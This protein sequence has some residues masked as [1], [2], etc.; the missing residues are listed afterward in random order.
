MI[1]KLDKYSIV[2]VLLFALLTTQFFV[3]QAVD[4]SNAIDG[5]WQYTLSSLRHGMQTLGVNIY[6][7]YGPLFQRITTFP[8]PKDGFVDFLVSGLLFLA[9]IVGISYILIQFIKLGSRYFP[10]LFPKLVL[11]FVL[12]LFVLSP[13]V[14]S[15]FFLTLLMGL[16]CINSEDNFKKQL[17]IIVPLSL[18]SL[19]KLSFSIS[20]L[21]LL[22]FALI[23][24]PIKFKQIKTALVS[25]LTSVVIF[26][27]M[28]S[29]LSI[30]SP[31][32]IIRY[33]Y[34]GL[35][36][37][38]SYSEFMG[39]S[40]ADN[41]LA[42]VSFVAIYMLCLTVF[43]TYSVI[44]IIRKQKIKHDLFLANLV[45]FGVGYFVLK[46]AIVRN[47]YS[48]IVAF[49]P[50]LPIFL[51]LLVYYSVQIFRK[52]FSDRV[53]LT[54]LVCS[55]IF[56]ISVQFIII[57]SLT[58]P[59]A[60]TPTQYLRAKVTILSNIA[61]QNPLIYPSFTHKRSITTQRQNIISY[62]T[63]GVEAYLKEHYSPS[64]NVIFYGNYTSL[65]DTLSNSVVY[66]PFLQNYAAFPP[67]TFDPIYI[68]MAKQNPDD[69][70]IVDET[71]PSINERIPS[72]ELNDFFQ[73]LKENYK[74]VYKNTETR[75]Y[76][77]EK[78]SNNSQSCSVISTIQSKKGTPISIPETVLSKDEYIRMRVSGASNPVEKLISAGLKP[79][80]YSISI[81]TKGGTGTKRTTVS[82][83][84]HGIAVKPLYYSY[85]D[86]INQT[87]VDLDSVAIT[88]G[89]DRNG[90]ISIVFDLCKY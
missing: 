84:E 43:I 4:L 72:H 39:L 29:V 78:V 41:K 79:P 59:Y 56:C 67:K 25:Y 49:L 54:A 40:I 20:F 87:P 28:F 36:N 5:S 83:I 35:V 2:S 23:R 9:L 76:L 51:T 11:L 31:M 26:T 73:Y 37:S 65:G 33:L 16:L 90:P 30:S 63:K 42:V 44:K 47:D 45:V 17:L 18:F 58:K 68:S 66:T 89:I 1:K 27:L 75:Q 60:K 46:Q 14:D 80:I 74:V 86:V 15:F 77:L 88:G 24:I 19:Y 10:K 50:F 34:Y 32:H 48:H 85:S 38:F 81:I 82:T 70:V 52:K 21:L 62:R 64:K 57:G 55:F 71:E 3:F 8:T 7:T 12:T 69:L 53:L 13:Q 61:T 22:P 6:Y